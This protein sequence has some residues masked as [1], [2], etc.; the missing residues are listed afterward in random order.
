MP[1]EDPGSESPYTIVRF[2]PYAIKAIAPIPFLSKKRREQALKAAGY[3]VFGLRSTAVTIDLVSDS[4]T[5]TMSVNQW[6]RLLIADESFSYQPS[7]DELVKKVSRFTGY[8]FILPIHQA[9]AAENILFSTIIKRGSTVFANNLF[10]TTKM[11]LRR[12]GTRIKELPVPDSGNIDLDRLK[13]KLN[14]K[15]RIVI[16]S[17]TS[18]FHGGQPVE[19][20][21]IRGVRRLI[22]KKGILILDACRF[23][24]NCYIESKRLRISLKNVIRKMFPLSDIFYLSTKKDLL[25]NI[26]GLIGIRDKLLY[27]RLNEKILLFEGFP[28][29]GGLAGRDLSAISQ[30]IDEITDTRYLSFRLNQVKRFGQMLKNLDVPVLE[31]FGC[32]AISIKGND[33]CGRITHPGFSG[34]AAIYLEGGVRSG[35]FDEDGEVIR[36]AVPRRVYTDS[37]LIYAAE[38][39]GRT[40]KKKGFLNLKPVYRPRHLTNFLIRFKRA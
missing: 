14:K 33:Y 39:I 29:H 2:E 23:A 24:E 13:K 9:R 5:G 27:E 31:P 1:I 26:G 7:Y 16:L 37:Q 11:H 21:N 15:D 10:S 40:Y 22:G 20:E 6:R 36:F 12:A 4:G 38:V 18:N 34:A 30:A 3:N 25:T 8:Q 19:I 17:V 32:H 35:V 28:T